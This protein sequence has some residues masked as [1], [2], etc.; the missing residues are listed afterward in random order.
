MLEE[1]ND[2]TEN[3]FIKIN[4]N[5]TTTYS[6]SALNDDISTYTGVK[7]V[8][9]EQSCS[10]NK[11]KK[12]QNN[13]NRKIKKQKSFSSI[14]ESS[15]SEY[16][17]SEIESEKDKNS[18]KS[19]TDKPKD[20]NIHEKE[21]EKEKENKLE[22]IKTVFE[23]DGGGELVYL[24]G[25]FC[26]W[27]KFYKMTKNDKGIFTVTLSL[28]RGFHQYKFKVDDNWFYSKNLPKFEDNGN[29]NNFIDTTDYSTDNNLEINENNE[30]NENKKNE[31]INEKPK[32]EIKNKSKGIKIKKPKKRYSSVHTVNFLNSQNNYTIY[33]PLRTELNIKP[34]SLPCLYK[35]HFTLNEDFKPKKEKKFTKIEYVNDSSSENSSSSNS[36][37]E[38]SS[39]QESSNSRVTI[40]GEIIPYVKFQNLYHIHSNHL[41]SKKN[42]YKG[43]NVTSMTSRYRIKFSTFIYY[44]PNEIIE[45]KKRRVHS[46]TVKLRK[47]K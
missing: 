15:N 27:Q 32:E 13:K 44:K 28:P 24:T 42:N 10:T 7:S 3:D 45:K 39:D 1:E 38:T 41:H 34:S 5:T 36:F 20:E 33:Y 29:V 14:T 12:S 30:N 26:D 23:W 8:N 6:I 16:S 19:E 43:S 11:N 22:E 17:K 21:K 31:K 18:Q 47:R 37:S 25:S 4:C 35:A 46:R 9:E 40:F 2:F